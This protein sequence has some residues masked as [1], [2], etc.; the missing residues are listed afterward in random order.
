[1]TRSAT[2]R[3]AGLERSEQMPPETKAWPGRGSGP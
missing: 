1:V 3:E 2:S